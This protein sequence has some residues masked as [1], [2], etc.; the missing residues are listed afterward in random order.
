[1]STVCFTIPGKPVA[2][3]RPRAAVVKGM[4][5]IYTPKKTA[6]YEAAARWAASVG[7]RGHD[8]F[9]G[10]VT[11]RFRFY[12]PIAKSWPKHRREE[13]SAGRLPH[14]GKPDVDN[15]AKVLDAM[16]GI[17]FADDSQVVRVEAEKLYGDEPR[18]E[19][20][21]LDWQRSA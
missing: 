7:M 19:V 20:E 9:T 14:T 15:C 4:A 10:P 12:F 5:R 8:L 18:T 21:V 17:V 6:D 16:N 11:V 2:K 3:G 1:M 13:A